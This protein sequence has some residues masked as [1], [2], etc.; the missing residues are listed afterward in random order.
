MFR[1][2]LIV[3]ATACLASPVVAQEA[4]PAP[5]TQPVV[6]I[7]RTPPSAEHI[8]LAERYLQ[9]VQ[10]EQMTKEVQRLIDQRLAG[11]GQLDETERAFWSRHMPPAITRMV[12]RVVREMTPTVAELHTEAELRALIAF[13][14]TPLGQSIALKQLELGARQEQIMMPAAIEMMTG[15]MAKYCAEF[16]CGTGATPQGS[17]PRG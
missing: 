8:Q 15:L 13:Y 10:T 7:G 5:E 9:L 4:T 17:K 16:D 12:S 6:V 1:C 14:E 3:A 2:L 11:D